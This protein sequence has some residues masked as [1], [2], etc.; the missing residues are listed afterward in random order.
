MTTPYTIRYRFKLTAGVHEIIDLQFEPGTLALVSIRT[1]ELPGWAKLDFHQCPHC[2]LSTTSHRYCPLAAN[3]SR[4]VDK[5]ERL[6]SFD[7]VDL[8]VTTTERSISQRTTAQSAISSIMGLMMATSGC[9]HT[10]F[11]RSMARFHLPLANEE[12]TVYRVTATYLLAQYF[13][14]KRGEAM[15]IDLRGLRQIYENMQ[16]INTAVADRLRAATGSDSFLNAITILDSFAQT[17]PMVIEESLGDVEY[18]FDAYFRELQRAG[19]S[20]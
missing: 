20:I 3:L 8:E 10:A 4:L 16:V 15:D 12:E 14:K 6:L 19:S 7:N 9:P 11:F 17:V 18:L 5:F 1:A 2:P 13:R